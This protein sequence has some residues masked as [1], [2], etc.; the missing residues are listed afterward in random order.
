M[1]TA[2]CRLIF[3]AN[4]ERSMLSDF[5][6]LLRRSVRISRSVGQPLL[7]TISSA[8]RMPACPM[9]ARFPNATIAIVSDGSYFA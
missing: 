5:T 7:K 6:T 3:R 9:T 4:L 1:V 2:S 8:L